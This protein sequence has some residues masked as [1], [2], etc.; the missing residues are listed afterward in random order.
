MRSIGYELI[1]KNRK[2]AEQANA[3]NKIRAERDL[4]MDVDGSLGQER[5][6]E[7]SSDV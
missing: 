5:R 3:R 2:K 7:N 1:K 6:S 4:G